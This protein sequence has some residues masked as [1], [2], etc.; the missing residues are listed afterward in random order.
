MTSNLQPHPAAA[1][2]PLLNEW[3][4]HDLAV[5]IKERG[6]REP[7]AV[8]NGQVLDGRNRLAACELV[9]VEPKV[10]YLEDSGVGG[11]PIAFVIS[12]NLRRRHMT[13]SQLAMV[14]V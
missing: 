1:L 4:L 14:G 7:V 11:D 2:F 12:C 13:V 5:D 10:R 8:Y 9:G 6:Q 3:D